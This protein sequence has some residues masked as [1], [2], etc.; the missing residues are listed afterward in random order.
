MA[1]LQSMENRKQQGIVIPKVKLGCQGFELKVVT[2]KSAKPPVEVSSSD[3]SS[4]DEEPPSKATVVVKQ[5]PAKK[6]KVDTTS[7]SSD[8]D[9]D[10]EPPA[11]AAIPSKEQPVG[12]KKWLSYSPWQERESRKQQ[13]RFF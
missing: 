8:D 3:E 1:M 4:S 10:E 11:K 9:S 12:L 5:T 6:G 2:K 7:D 13:F